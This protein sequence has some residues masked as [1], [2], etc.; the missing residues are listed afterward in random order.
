MCELSTMDLEPSEDMGGKEMLSA[1]GY[2]CTNQMGNG[3]LSDWPLETWRRVEDPLAGRAFIGLSGE[4]ARRYMFDDGCFATPLPFS[5]EEMLACAK[6]MQ[7]LKDGDFVM[8]KKKPVQS[9]GNVDL[10]GRTDEIVDILN[11]RTDNL[12]ISERGMVLLWV[13]KLATATVE[14]DVI[15][16]VRA[17]DEAERNDAYDA[18]F[19]SG[20]KA[21]AHQ[22]EGVLDEHGQSGSDAVEELRELLNEVW[23]DE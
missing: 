11:E 5:Y 9:A 1:L 15:D 20:M 3:L 22:V 18:G 16:A 7:E 21:F 19:E 8:E 17:Q 2:E 23:C 14:Q 6:R 10:I 13:S 4:K 12:S